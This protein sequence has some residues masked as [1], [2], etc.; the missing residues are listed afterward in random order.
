LSTTGP[1]VLG[2]RELPGAFRGAQHRA[3]YDVL[4]NR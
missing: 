4:G 1:R 3:L 2:I